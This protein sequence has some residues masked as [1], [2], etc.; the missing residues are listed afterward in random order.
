VSDFSQLHHWFFSAEEF[1]IQLACLILLVIT[2]WQIIK[3]KI[4][5]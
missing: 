4:G 5:L 3:K 2:I 1:V